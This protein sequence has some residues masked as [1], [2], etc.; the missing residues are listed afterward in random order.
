MDALSYAHLST[1]PGHSF[2]IRDSITNE[3]VE[4][5]LQPLLRYVIDIYIPSILLFSI[6]RLLLEANMCIHLVTMVV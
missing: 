2:A 5:V 3:L 4:Q 1:Y 6:D